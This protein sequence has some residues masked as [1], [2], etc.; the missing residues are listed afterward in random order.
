[1]VPAVPVTRGW[2]IKCPAWVE[3][4]NKVKALN[5]WFG[6]LDIS[7]FDVLVISLN[8][9]SK[10]KIIHFDWVNQNSKV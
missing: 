8:K 6:R 5:R 4:H 9:E 7:I 2:V 10:T 1:M 3:T